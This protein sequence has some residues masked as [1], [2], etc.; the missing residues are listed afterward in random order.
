MAFAVED[1]IEAIRASRQLFLKHIE[2][3]KEEQWDWKPYPECKSIRETIAHLVTGDRAFIP[4]MEASG[5]VDWASLEESERDLDKLMVTIKKTRDEL[6]TAIKEKFADTPLDQEI[7][8]MGM[9][10]K[11]GAVLTS[12]PYEDHYHAG[13]VA[14]IRMATDPSWDYYKEVY[15]A[16]M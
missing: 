11:F 12:I 2:N 10:M 14:F 6:C 3:L 15:G 1:Y 7:K 13:Q 9:D 4:L 5:D 8:F 16:E